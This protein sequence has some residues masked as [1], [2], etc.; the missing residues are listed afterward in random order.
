MQ[1]S[2]S[3]TTALLRASLAVRWFGMPR[4]LRQSTADE[5]FHTIAKS[6]VALSIH[7]WPVAHHLLVNV[8]TSRLNETDLSTRTLPPDA[9]LNR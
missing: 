1:A 9:P 7:R 6:S 2:R 5:E 3:G 8:T 4:S